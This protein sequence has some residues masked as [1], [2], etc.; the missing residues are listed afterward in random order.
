MLRLHAKKFKNCTN[1]PIYVSSGC[2]LTSTREFAEKKKGRRIAN[3]FI[4]RKK[5]RKR[6]VEER[7][8]IID[9]DITNKEPGI[10]YAVVVQEF[11]FLSILYTYIYGQGVIRSM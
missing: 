2:G 3:N 1:K 7:Q 11:T 8:S 10:T 4:A 6:Q 5:F 9:N